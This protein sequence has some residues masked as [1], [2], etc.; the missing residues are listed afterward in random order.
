[1]F[2]AVVLGSLALSGSFLSFQ[3]GPSSD[4]EDL[5]VLLQQRALHAP[6]PAYP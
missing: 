5:S 1:M 3:G 2:K 4:N 6:S